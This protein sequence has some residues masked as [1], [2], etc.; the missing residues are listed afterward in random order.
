MAGGSGTRLWP[1]SRCNKPKQFHNLCS[2]KSLIQETYD[3]VKDIVPKENIFVSLVK[4]ILETSQKQLSEVPKENF[5]VEADIRNTGPAIAYAAATIARRN[6]QAV[7]V[8]LPSDHA[9]DK[10]EEFINSIN[11]VLNFIDKN[12]EYLATVGLKPTSPDTG[13][14]YIKIGKKFSGSKLHAVDCFVEKPNL[15]KAKEYLKSGKFLWNASYFCWRANK[16]LDMYKTF[17]PEIYAGI[18]KIITLLGKKGSKEKIEN[19]YKDL[20]KEP[21]DTAIAEKVEKIAVLPADLGWSDIGNWTTLYEFLTARSG[22]HT[23]S[24]GNH[25]GFDDKNCLIYA[26]DKLLTTVGLKDII[27]VDTPDVTFVCNKNRAQD[28]KK[29]IEKIK[30][31][32]KSKYL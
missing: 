17:A 31:K 25:I 15:K 19:I 30:E 21:I 18:S 6:P 9:I 14:G 24:R 4:P 11:T 20:P 8:T 27:V 22:N 2:S 26:Q 23:V 1:M 32:G 12:P 3:R 10:L 29:L 16:L 5:I 7:V 28:V 13:L